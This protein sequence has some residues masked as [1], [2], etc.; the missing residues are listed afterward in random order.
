MVFFVW[1]S[2]VLGFVAMG[3]VALAIAW[4]ALVHW[5]I[6]LTIVAVRLLWASWEVAR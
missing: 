6:A 2:G 4:L 5:Q 1:L 3:A